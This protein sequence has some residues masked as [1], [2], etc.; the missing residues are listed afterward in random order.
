MISTT[1]LNSLSSYPERN[2]NKKGREDGL[3]EM[4]FAYLII[5]INKV[6]YTILSELVA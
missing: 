6:I 1:C 5:G 2:K 4:A 3:L